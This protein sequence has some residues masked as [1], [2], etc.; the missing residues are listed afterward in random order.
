MTLGKETHQLLKQGQV[1]SIGGVFTVSP[2]L[3]NR[4]VSVRTG[5]RP[6][7]MELVQEDERRIPRVVALSST[8][9]ALLAFA[10]IN[11]LDVKVYGTTEIPR[12]PQSRPLQ[13]AAIFEIS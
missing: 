7:A 2:I 10:G 11:G 12:L 6:E 3:R 9:D 13:E 5:R 8:R 4:A 1:H